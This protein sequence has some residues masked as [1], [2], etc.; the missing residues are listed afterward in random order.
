MLL[1]RL[2]PDSS[3]SIA[4]SAF[5]FNCIVDRL[6]GITASSSALCRTPAELFWLG[7]SIQAVAGHK[8][9]PHFLFYYNQAKGMGLNSPSNDE[10][11]AYI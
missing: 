11:R 7:L 1:A 4:S 10:E 9:P 2:L 5:F 6:S 8:N 3:S